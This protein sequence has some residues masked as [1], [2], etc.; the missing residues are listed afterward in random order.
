MYPAIMIIGVIISA[1]PFGI[2]LPF[3][4]IPMVLLGSFA[5]ITGI[6]VNYLQY[7]LVMVPTGIAIIIG[8]I[9]ACRFILRPDVSKMRDF[10]VTKLAKENS[11][12]TRHQKAVL[13]AFAFAL[14]L[15]LIPGSLPTSWA[16]TQFIS[17]MG[18]ASLMIIC[19]VLFT[20]IKVDGQPLLD[21]NKSA[22]GGLNWPIIFM[23]VVIML[24][25]SLLMSDATGLKPWLVSLLSPILTGFSGVA[26]LIALFAIALI[27]TNFMNNIIVGIMFLPVLGTFYESVGANP[28][29]GVLLILLAINTAFLTPAASPATAMCFARTDWIRTKDVFKVMVTCVIVFTVI[30]LPII[31]GLGHLIF[32]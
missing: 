13:I 6:Q 32:A 14:I 9:L 27:L 2:M 20:L 23:I 25:S 4:A 26:F 7:M 29:I 17:G 8:Y 5:Q 18:N 11:D 16:F 15:L 30:G 28:I 22:K 12:I 10:D 24:L 1:S 31:L 19:T 21:F 3:K